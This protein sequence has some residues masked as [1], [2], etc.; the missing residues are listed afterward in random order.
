MKIKL[1]VIHPLGEGIITGPCIKD[2][3]PNLVTH[4][5]KSTEVT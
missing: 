4:Q 1:Y 2:E 3:D 5:A